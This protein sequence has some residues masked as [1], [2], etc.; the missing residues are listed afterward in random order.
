M[1]S[2]KDAVVTILFFILMVGLVV[3]GAMGLG[4]LFKTTYIGLKTCALIA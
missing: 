1:M 4:W 2:L 3:A